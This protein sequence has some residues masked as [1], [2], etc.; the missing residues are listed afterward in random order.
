MGGGF[1]KCA[2][3]ATAN[4]DKYLNVEQRPHWLPIQ[5]ISNQLCYVIM[6][7]LCHIELDLLDLWAM[8][9]WAT[10]ADRSSYI[11]YFVSK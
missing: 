5:E 4:T 6:M 8:L 3:T 1:L 11:Q 10:N 9:A 2:A 7:S